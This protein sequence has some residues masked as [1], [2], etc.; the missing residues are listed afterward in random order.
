MNG[1]QL[2]SKL[3]IK[4]DY[5]SIQNDTPVSASYFNVFVKVNE[6]KVR[7]IPLNINL[8]GLL[9]NIVNGYRPNKHDK[10]AVVLLDELVDD[11]SKV[12]NQSSDI[13]VVKG[14]KKFEL[15]KVEEDEIEVSE[16]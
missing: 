2:T 16:V 14:S 12:A 10:S 5:K 8:L 11:I 4:P 7:P 13:Q 15:R 6:Q 3:D 1:Y 9:K